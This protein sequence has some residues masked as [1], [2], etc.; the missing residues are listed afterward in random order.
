MANNIESK[1]TYY[2]LNSKGW[3]TRSPI[4]HFSNEDN[5]IEIMI[6]RNIDYDAA[7]NENKEL[8]KK[9]Y[10]NQMTVLFIRMK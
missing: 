4:S 10:V 8:W 5:A 3:K 1:H 2:N 7:I 6:K 9:Y